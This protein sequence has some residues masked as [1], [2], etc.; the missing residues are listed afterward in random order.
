MIRGIYVAAT[1][2]SN[3]AKNIDVASNNITNSG[4][5]GFKKDALVSGSFGECLSYQLANGE[6]QELGSVTNGVTQEE[7]YTSFEQGS[8]KQTGQSTDL[9]IL[10]QGFFNLT[11]PTGE[12]LLTRDGHF[13][14]NEAGFLSDSTGNLV[15]GTTGPINVARADFTVGAGGEIIANGESCGTLLITCPSDV[16]S[17]TKA[18]ENKFIDSNPAQS[19]EVLQGSIKQ[20][21]LEGS[22]VDMVDEMS[23]LM[24][25]SRSYQSCGQLIKMMDKVMERTVNDIGSL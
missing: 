1:G 12:A 4:T 10:G 11:S 7:V 25:F 21:Y 18:G 13:V 22:N 20:G 24:E 19:N 6:S 14:V 2:L 15:L 17:L 5:A 23:T 8:L 16:S 3:S 9:A